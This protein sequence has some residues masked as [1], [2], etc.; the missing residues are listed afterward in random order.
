M[1]S[2]RVKQCNHQTPLPAV[3]LKESDVAG[4]VKSTSQ[5]SQ[6]TN[7]FYG[8]YQ[9]EA[10]TQLLHTESTAVLSCCSDLQGAHTSSNKCIFHLPLTKKR[11]DSISWWLIIKWTGLLPCAPPHFGFWDRPKLVITA[12]I[13]LNNQIHIL[14]S[15][16]TSFGSTDITFKLDG[17]APLHT[18]FMMYLASCST[19]RGLFNWECY[20]LTSFCCNSRILFLSV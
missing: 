13:C 8:S 6:L 10:N 9:Y 5:V 11:Q 19:T 14:K 16:A 12:S 18:Y 20:F 3:F 2:H 4:C 15:P 1:N 17:E 7:L